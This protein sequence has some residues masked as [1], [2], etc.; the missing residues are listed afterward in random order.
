[1]KRTLKVFTII[2]CLTLTL[3]LASCENIF[4][5]NTTSKTDGT[6]T[7]TVSTEPPHVHNFV[8]VDCLSPKTCECGETEG[9]V[10]GHTQAEDDGDCTTEVLCTVCESVLVEKQE[11]HTD[12]DND[13]QCDR[14][15]CNQ[16]FLPEISTAEELI[17]A[18]ETG[19]KFK[20]TC[21]INVGNNA[22][23]L[24]RGVLD[25]DLNGFTITTEFWNGISV[26][27]NSTLTIRNGSVINVSNICNAVLVYG[28][29]YIY[30]CYIEGND[31]WSLY[32]YGGTA[33]V[34]NTEIKYGIIADD[35]SEYPPSVVIANNNVSIVEGD[36]E[37]GIAVMGRGQ[38]VFGVDPT[39][40]LVALD[41]QGVAIDNG[42]GTWTVKVEQQI[43][44]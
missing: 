40:Y 24:Y 10:V 34:E 2:C 22:L 20:L 9:E 18:F 15:G 35:Y 39:Q 21:D 12:E 23:A 5:F 25:L 42:D 44:E 37:Y 41:N 32:V 36:N 19:G 13:Y 29:A 33:V 28:T 30:D 6:T 27:S 3:A 16:E 31:Y 8:Y 14:E 43:E 1:M 17:A 38:I 26:S 4:N 7:T 11:K